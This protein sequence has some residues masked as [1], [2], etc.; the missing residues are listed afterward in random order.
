LIVSPLGKVRIGGKNVAPNA[1]WRTVLLVQLS[2]GAIFVVVSAVM[3][4]I[5]LDLLGTR[6][7][8]VI[9][10]HSVPLRSRTRLTILSFAALG[11]FVSHIAQIWVWAVVYMMIGEFNSLEVALYFSTASFTTLGFGDILASSEWRLMASCEAAA[12]MLLFGLST[13][14]LFEVLREIL[15]ERRI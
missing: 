5:V 8:A 7:R 13:A 14:F 11:L 15:S 10:V 1:H 9:A 6:V 2:V 4:I 3:H 12:G